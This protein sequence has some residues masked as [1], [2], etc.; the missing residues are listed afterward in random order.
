MIMHF[1]RWVDI[2]I[3]FINSDL[4]QFIRVE[5]CG[6]ASIKHNLK[7]LSGLYYCANLNYIIVKGNKA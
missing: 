2:K 6:V 7:I 5:P 1:E 4:E 3:W